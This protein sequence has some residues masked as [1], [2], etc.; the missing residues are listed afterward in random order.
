MSVREPSSEKP[1]ASG[2]LTGGVRCIP[3]RWWGDRWFLTSL[4]LTRLIATPAFNAVANLN[5]ARLERSKD[6]EGEKEKPLLLRAYSCLSR[7]AG[8]LRIFMSTQENCTLC[9]TGRREH[10][11]FAVDKRNWTKNELTAFCINLLGHGAL[12]LLGQESTRICA[13][14]CHTSDDSHHTE[15]VNGESGAVPQQWFFLPSSLFAMDRSIR[16]RF[17]KHSDCGAVPDSPRL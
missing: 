9:S 13:C 14:A 5:G 2:W 17:G 10:G 4:F 7:S 12:H 8:Q 6:A 3:L 11:R 15:A 1:V 16:N